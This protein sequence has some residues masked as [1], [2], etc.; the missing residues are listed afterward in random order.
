MTAPTHSGFIGGLSVA[1]SPGATNRLAKGA[2]LKK[3]AALHITINSYNKR[4]SV[5]TQFATLRNLLSGKIDGEMGDYFK[6]VRDGQITLVVDTDNADVIA[7]LLDLVDELSQSS[8]S[9]IKLTIAGGAEAHL[10]AKELGQAGVGVILTR[11]RPFPAFW[12][13]KNM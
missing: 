12:F 6:L 5:S 7:T 3:I 2:V 1:F 9:K 8:G 11:P 13:G 4:P 10:L